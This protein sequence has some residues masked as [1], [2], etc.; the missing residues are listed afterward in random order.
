MEDYYNILNVNHDIDINELK[1][2]CKSKLKEFKLLPFLTKNDEIRFKQIKK[3]YFIFNNPEYKKKYD[4]AI[5]KNN[6]NN[7]NNN[8]HVKKKNNNNM[9]IDRIFSINNDINKKNTSFIDNTTSIDIKGF[10]DEDILPYNYD[11]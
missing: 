11:V 5:L 2:I 1:I 7:N 3:A 9:L 4:T 6:N 10:E 8:T